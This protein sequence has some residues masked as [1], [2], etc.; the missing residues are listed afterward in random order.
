MLTRAEKT[1]EWRT[2]QRSTS[3]YLGR[4]RV[5][6]LQWGLT[7]NADE[8]Y[9]LYCSLPGYDQKQWRCKDQD[10]AEAK[11]VRILDKWLSATGLS[12]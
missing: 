3:G 8:P 11:A 9:V 1:I 5:F 6:S 4:V 10:D 2:Q 7:R 12:S